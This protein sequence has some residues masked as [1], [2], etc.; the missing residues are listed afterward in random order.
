MIVIAIVIM[1]GAVITTRK[2][3]DGS[4][5]ERD[6]SIMTAA[7]AIRA[8]PIRA[9]SPAYLFLKIT[10][11]E[12]NENGTKSTSNDHSSLASLGSNIKTKGTSL[13]VKT[14]YGRS[15]QL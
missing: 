11:A 4:L 3:S 7:K 1:A 10:K 6:I 13:F 14:N 8:K 15:R 5:H 9:K 2:K 12:D